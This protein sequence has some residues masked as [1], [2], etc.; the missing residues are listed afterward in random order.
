MPPGAADFGQC[1]IFLPTRGPTMSI[2]LDRR[3]LLVTTH[4]SV[5]VITLLLA[6]LTVTD[7]IALWYIYL[8]I[9]ILGTI[10]AINMPSRMAIVS[11]MVDPEDIKKAVS[12][13]WLALDEFALPPPVGLRREWR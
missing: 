3:K 5:I 2:S 11:D 1:R 7:L 12:P 13:K 8:G 4:Y 6:F 10:Q 9:F